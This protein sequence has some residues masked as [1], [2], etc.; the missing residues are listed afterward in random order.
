[1]LRRFKKRNEGAPS[2]PAEAEAAEEIRLAAEALGH[3]FSDG[4]GEFA[5]LDLDAAPAHVSTGHADLENEST[6]G[7]L[8]ERD[9]PATAPEA[10]PAGGGRRK[11]S[12]AGG[13]GRAR[14]RKS[15]PA[16]APG[17]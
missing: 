1:M 3:P 8:P 12:A 2:L 14:V 16:T 13:A 7:D 6:A 9:K 15:P 11:A 17:A 5:P 10:R 4:A